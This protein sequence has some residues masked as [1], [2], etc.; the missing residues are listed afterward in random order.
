MELY[1]IPDIIKFA[2]NTEKQLNCKIYAV[3]GFVRDNI[4]GLKSIDLDFVVEGNAIVVANHFYQKLGGK[5]TVYKKFFTASLK[6]KN[7]FVI[8]FA[9]ARTEKYPTPASMPVVSLSVLKK[10]LFRRD[11]TINAMAIPV[12]HY[13]LPVT[14]VID[15]CGGLNDIKNKLIRVLHKKS[16]IDDPTRILRAIRYSYRFG[17]KIEKNTEKWLTSAIKKNLLS[18]VSAP[19]IRDEFIKSLEEKNTK[20]I[21]KELKKRGVLKYINN[22][23]N[24]SAILA[25]NEPL[26]TRLK[27]LLK[28]FSE[29]QRKSFLQKLCLPSEIS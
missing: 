2:K 3:G 23:L 8:D 26:R 9:T 22:N 1:K 5:L 6:L 24:I 19:R 29:E 17:F 13:P 10:D 27:K 15:P 4:L 12:T 28:N 7:G 25:K 18:L 21:L 14:D 16:F 20:E 11:F